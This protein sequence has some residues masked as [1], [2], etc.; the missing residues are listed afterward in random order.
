MAWQLPAAWVSLPKQTFIRCQVLTLVI[1]SAHGFQ[2]Y[3]VY[4][5]EGKVGI[6]SENGTPCAIQVVFFFREF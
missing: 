3:L 2:G 4:I 6:A 1:Q 5:Y